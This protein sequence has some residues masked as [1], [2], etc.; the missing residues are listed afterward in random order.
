[1]VGSGKSSLVL[2]YARQ[3]SS[4]L[5]LSGRMEPEFEPSARAVRLNPADRAESNPFK[6]ANGPR[7]VEFSDDVQVRSI[8]GYYYIVHT[9]T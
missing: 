4:F 8:L 5:S 7:K 9:F 2:F 3:F 1:M 6:R